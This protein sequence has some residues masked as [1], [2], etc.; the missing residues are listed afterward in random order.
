MGMDVI[1]YADVKIQLLC[2]HKQNALVDL[3]RTQAISLVILT[4]GDELD[5][6]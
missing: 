5:L 4:F 3:L 1:L 6:V 2:Y